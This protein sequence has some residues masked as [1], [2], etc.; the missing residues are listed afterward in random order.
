MVGAQ[1]N[2]L[3]SILKYLPCAPTL[4]CKFLQDWYMSMNSH[5]RP[6]RVDYYDD[7]SVC[8]NIQLRDN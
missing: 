1:G 2:N 8:I 4:I 7:V 3:L 5:L 6:I